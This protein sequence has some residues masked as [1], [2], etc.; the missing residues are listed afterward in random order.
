[1]NKSQIV[2][3]VSST[4]QLNKTEA[5][6]VLEA[7]LAAI[8]DGLLNDGGVRIHG[9]GGFVVK[10]TKERPGRNPKTGAKIVIKAAKKISFNPSETLKDKM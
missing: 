3:H 5:G 1:M 8:T 10:E 6:K 4:T 2:D 9:F 7:V